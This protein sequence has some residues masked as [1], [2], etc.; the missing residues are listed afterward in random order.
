M[1]RKNFTLIELLIVIAIIAILAGMLLPTLGKARE[2]ARAIGCISNEKQLALAFGSYQNDSADY[3]PQIRGAGDGK[4][5]SWT[6]LR[7]RYATPGQMICSGMTWDSDWA[8]T[9]MK[10]WSHAAEQVHLNGSDFYVYVSYGLNFSGLGGGA[11]QLDSLTG[12]GTKMSQLRNPS[13]CI[14]AADSWNSANRDVGRYIGGFALSNILPSTKTY[15]AEAFPAHSARTLI[16]VLWADG[17]VRAEKSTSARSS[18]YNLAPFAQGG[19]ANDP[20]N[21]FDLK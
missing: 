1:S 13:G 5:W 12:T 7:D 3:W 16:N 18:V 6:F 11:A 21:H 20:E 15:R 17:S 2:R 19:V 14:T 4:P 8:R 10:D 9:K